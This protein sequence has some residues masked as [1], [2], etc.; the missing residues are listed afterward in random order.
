MAQAQGL[1]PRLEL[2]RRELGFEAGEA[3]LPKAIHLNHMIFLVI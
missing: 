1:D 3:R 2:L